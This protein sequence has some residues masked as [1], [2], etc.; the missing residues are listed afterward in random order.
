MSEELKYEDAVRDVASKEE[1]L[2]NES[3]QVAW[4][5]KVLETAMTLEAE[6][7]IALAEAAVKMAA[8]ESAW[9]ATI[10]E[11]TVPGP[12]VEVLMGVR[13]AHGDAE[14]A[15]DAA[16]A[17]VEAC[18]ARLAAEMDDE[19]AAMAVF[20]NYKAVITAHDEAAA[21]AV[22]A[23]EARVAKMHA[24][25]VVAALIVENGKVFEG[26][27]CAP[28]SDIADAVIANVMATST[29]TVEKAANKVVA[30]LKAMEDQSVLLRVA[31]KVMDMFI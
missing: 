11:G 5:K 13:T 2:E 12:D 20:N 29:G 31:L 9:A 28:A 4:A 25:A 3:K 10:G 19:E 7:E 23:E 17:Q 22:A 26:C 24:D 16:K 14:M 18:K 30:K 15:L 6:A 1:A 8:D 21:A 27:N